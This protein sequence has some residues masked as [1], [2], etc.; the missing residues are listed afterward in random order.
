MVVVHTA[1]ASHRTETEQER[2]HR[3]N[4]YAD[5]AAFSEALRRRYCGDMPPRHLDPIPSTPLRILRPKAGFREG[6]F[7]VRFEDLDPTEKI[8]DIA[9]GEVEALAQI[10]YNAYLEWK[11]QSPTSE[12]QANDK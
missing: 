11:K 4:D 9:D 7:Y 1:I 8:L 5:S 2:D 3:C 12:S 10:I 6:P